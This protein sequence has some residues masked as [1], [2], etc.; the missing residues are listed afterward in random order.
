MGLELRV[1]ALEKR[2]Q[3][4]NRL[5]LCPQLGDGHGF[6]RRPTVRGARGRGW[7]PCRR[8]APLQLPPRRRPG[9]GAPWRDLPA[10]LDCSRTSGGG[11]AE[12]SPSGGALRGRQ[13]RGGGRRSSSRRSSLFPRPGAP[14]RCRRH[15][16]CRFFR[17]HLVCAV[18]DG[19]GPPAQA[20]YPWAAHGRL[21][22]V[23]GHRLVRTLLVS[24]SAVSAIYTALTL[25]AIVA[26]KDHGAT[27]TE[28]G[29]MLSIASGAGFLGALL[30]PRLS[31]HKKPSVVVLG[32]FWVTA[33]V[34]PLMAVD[35]GPLRP[36][37]PARGGHP[38][39]PDGEHHPGQ[40]PGHPHPRC[41]PG[42]GE[43][44]GLLRSWRA[45]AFCSTRCRVVGQP[46]R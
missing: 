34:V 1:T 44:C 35:Q 18:P 41:H 15:Q 42:S 12:D 10:G 21:R 39:R 3:A 6:G 25:A 17:L 24:A 5:N 30:A 38:A 20:K 8:G 4:S 2:Q 23:W 14:L 29:L 28:V 32:I 16:L 46:H 7:L 11:P 40:L 43:Q 13:L 27:S 36:G 9:N 45:L 33:A 22:W 37:C 19:D 26:A 31:N